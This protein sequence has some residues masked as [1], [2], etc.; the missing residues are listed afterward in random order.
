MGPATR[1]TA[2]IRPSRPSSHGSPAQPASPSVS[3]F[4]PSHAPARVRAVAIVT[5][6][7]RPIARFRGETASDVVRRRLRARPGGMAIEEDVVAAIVV[8]LIAV[9]LGRLQL[10]VF[11]EGLGS[12]PIAAGVAGRSPLLQRDGR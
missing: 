9:L 2:A 7:G 4:R 12:D 10:I 3:P 1:A 8:A 5:D 6:V 11:V